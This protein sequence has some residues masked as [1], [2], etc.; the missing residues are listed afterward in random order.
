MSNVEGQSVKGMMPCYVI[1][2]HTAATQRALP[3]PRAREFPGLR[4]FVSRTEP[5]GR[6]RYQLNVGYFRLEEQAQEAL[7]LLRP[8]YR[9]AWV[10]AAFATPEQL[11]QTSTRK[12][13]L[14][15]AQAGQ[16]LPLEIKPLLPAAAQ[17]DTETNTVPAA[18]L[19]TLSERQ[20]LDTLNPSVLH[21]EGARP[22][23]HVLELAPWLS[24]EQLGT[25]AHHEIFQSYRLYV[26][27]CIAAGQWG[28]SLRLGFFTHSHDA[29]QVASFMGADYPNAR[30][31]TI[32]GPERLAV[33][34]CETADA[35]T[36]PRVRMKKMNPVENRVQVG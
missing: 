29:M 25:I 2:L 33:Q 22:L 5:G 13:A 31:I 9:S 24:L 20:V 4:L 23:R 14:A 8:R 28:F 18:P 16:V 11:E 27:D 26:K 3:A 19:D 7:E 30:V 17:L 32:S 12:Q 21:K 34:R 15:A 6:G 35:A 36:L 1:V 10:S